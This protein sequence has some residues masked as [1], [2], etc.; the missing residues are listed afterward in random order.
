[1]QLRCVL[2]FSAPAVAELTDDREETEGAPNLL[3]DKAG[4]RS[5]ADQVAWTGLTRSSS[6]LGGAA[7]V[8]SRRAA[9]SAPWLLFTFVVVVD[10]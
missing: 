8:L 3:T 5:V 6:L 10:E 2:S 1:M 4:A 7:E 9:R